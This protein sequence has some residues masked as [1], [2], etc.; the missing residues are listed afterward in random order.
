MGLACSNIRLL[1]LTARKADCEYGISVASMRKMAITR[2]QSALASE[3]NSKLQAKSIS[4][5]DEGKYN[6]INYNYLMGYGANYT[7]ITGG[8]RPLKD[9]NSMILTDY[10]GQVVLSADYANAIT[11]V[12]GSSANRLQRSGCIECGLCKC[13]N[14][15][16]RFVCNGFSRKRRD[17]LNGSNTCYA[18]GIDS[19]IYRRTV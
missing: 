6:K 12:L 14:R 8:T 16:F 2:E 7:A 11:A 5:Y 10:K 19:G 1:T 9:E 13:H 4:F 15:C 3:Y 18:C 17:F